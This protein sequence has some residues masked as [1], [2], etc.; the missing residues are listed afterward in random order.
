MSL[1]AKIE[2]LNDTHDRA[3]FACGVEALDTYFKTRARQDA[4]RN[5]SAPFVLVMPDG[6]IG[7][8]Y[9]LSSTAVL[10]PDLPPATQKKLP[11]YPLIPA[12]LLGRLAVDLKCRGQ[13]MGRY[14]LADALHR[15][16]T[17]EIATF[18]MIVDAKDDRAREFYLREGFHTL[19]DNRDRL[20]LPT[21]TAAELFK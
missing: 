20:F 7:G 12:T 10:L 17:A 16:V 18:A 5:L 9:T 2:G 3:S 21:A 1:A 8:Y 13:G 15:M 11:R 4:T 19:L 14:L 6:G